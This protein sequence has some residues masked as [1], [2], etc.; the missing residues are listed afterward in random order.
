MRMRTLLYVL[1]AGILVLSAWGVLSG[2]EQNAEYGPR[3]SEK[4]ESDYLGAAEIYRMLRGNV[5]TGEVEPQDYVKMRNAVRKYA[6]KTANQKDS[7]PIDWIEM[8]PDNVGGR[9][10]AILILDENNLMA[11][12]VSGGLWRT[13]NQ[14]DTWTQITTFPNCN[15]GSICQAGNGDIYVGTG[16]RFDGAGGAGQ[17]GFIGQ[18]V[19]RSING[20]ETWTVVPDTDAGVLGLG[21]WT[22]T[23]AL[24]MDPNNP[25]RV[26]VG[27]NAGFGYIEGDNVVIGEAGGLP[28]QAVDDIHIAHD[29][30]YM[31]VAMQGGRVY[32]STDNTFSNFTEEFGNGDGELPQSGLGRARVYVVPQNPNHA[33]VLYATGA[34]FFGG[35]YH[36]GDFGQTWENIWPSG[37]PEV[38]P[39][40]RSQGIYDLTI[41]AS[42]FEPEIAYVGGIEFWRS[43][44]NYQAELAALPFDSPGLDIDMHVDV[45]EIVYSPEG[46]MWVGTDGGLYKSLNNGDTYIETNR[47]FNVTQYYGID[48]DPAG[49]VI[50][51]TQDNGTHWIPND[52]SLLSD[53]SAV[54]LTGGD[55]FDCAV[56]DVTEAQEQVALTTSQY[57]V[58]FRVTSSGG[59]SF[60]YDDEVNDLIGDDGEVGPFYTVNRLYEDTDDGVSERYVILVNPYEETITDSTFILETNNL[61]LAFEY[62]LP[63]G[64]ELRYWVELIRPERITEEP[65]TEDPDYF[66]LDPQELTSEIEECDTT[67]TQVGEEEVIDEI[68]PVDSC[69]YFEPLDSTI[70]ITVGFDTTFVMEPIFDIDIDCTTQYFYASDTLFNIA[71]RVK[72]QDPYTTMFTMG[73]IG[74]Q[75]VW[76]TRDALDFNQQPNWWRLGTA[77][78][79]GGT[80]A[81]E[82]V[83]G[84]HPEAG[85][86]MFL[87]GWN[88]Q[89]WRVSG[90]TNLWTD[91]DYVDTLNNATGEPTFDSDGDGIPDGDGYLDVLD[92]DLVFNTGAPVTGIS[93]DPNDP[94][95]VVISIGGYGGNSKVRE[96]FNALD[97]D[98]T[99]GD[100]NSIWLNDP[101]LD[102]MPVYDVVVDVTD[103][104][105]Q[106]IVAGTEFGAWITND[107][108]DTW[109]ISN[110]GMATAFDNYACPIFDLKQQ[111]RGIDRWIE[112]TNSGVIYAGTHGRGI[113]RSEA[114]GFVNVEEND[115]DSGLSSDNLLVYPN[116]VSTG[117]A[118]FDLDLTTTTDVLITV[119][120]MNGQRIKQINKDNLAR[121]KQVIELDLNDLSNGTYLLNVQ[122]GASSETARFVVLK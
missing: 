18:G 16:S 54:D 91:E 31:L 92:W 67:F 10:R 55:G 7:E 57:G 69:F 3:S 20:G 72:I 61:N 78:G 1:G 74:S 43:G 71:E 8:G 65:L 24:E 75:G 39:L 11:G 100:W 70:C 23:D 115:D 22:A 14:G 88:G 107:G 81:I 99:S 19:Y 83:V 77:P 60:I 108:G 112:P 4:A 84:D 117:F 101:V 90:L 51:G 15:V 95:H 44:P 38:T 118:R 106:T 86:V 34:G 96:T 76:M 29:G 97:E 36:S 21:D 80:K 87:S 105:G 120:N 6:E 48:Y 111:W 28:S 68:I 27:S 41:A 53:L 45:H 98:L 94:N 66:W 119:F 62:T 13:T 52:G 103:E 47:G 63:E 102:G 121:G 9:T 17:S 89:V 79:G 109:T 30:S 56:P 2:G 73:F 32:R 64:V 85:D 50:G 46:V 104:S 37:N 12:G 33:Y 93:V 116:P 25:N 122:A 58:L 110:L 114:S 40:P 26:W 59:T 5:E 35:V 42:P 113:F 49:G 82:Y